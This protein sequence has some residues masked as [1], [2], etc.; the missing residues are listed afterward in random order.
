MAG[1][2]LHMRRRGAGII[3]FEL[4]GTVRETEAIMD[5]WGRTGRSAARASLLLD[6]LYL[7]TYGPLLA[8][9]CE[10]AGERLSACGI[11]ALGRVRRPV[12]RM[13]LAAALLDA[14]ENTV[15]LGVLAGRRGRWPMIARTSALGKFALLSVGGLYIVG[16][17]GAL[18]TPTPTPTSH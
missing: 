18:R 2:E 17:L 14:V 3:E 4:A 5:A 16:G 11:H 10:V 12:A 13:Q 1:P 9:A 8:S 15:L 7:A 6:Y